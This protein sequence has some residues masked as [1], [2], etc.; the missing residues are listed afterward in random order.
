MTKEGTA[1]LY[2]FSPQ[3][4]PAITTHSGWIINEF[5]QGLIMKT[6]LLFLFTLSA[7][8]AGGYLANG[9]IPGAT[10]VIASAIAASLTAWTLRQ[11]E[12]KFVPLIRVSPWRLRLVGT[13]RRPPAP[14]FRLAA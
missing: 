14:P 8:L 4:L 2:T 5:N 9:R 6:Y 3:G 10:L 1:K 11:Y 13:G 12:R 7:L